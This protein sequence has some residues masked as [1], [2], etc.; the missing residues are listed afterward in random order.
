M[1]PLLAPL[2]EMGSTGALVA[3]ILT[4]FKV[5]DNKSSKRNGGSVSEKMAVMEKEVADCKET[6]ES[7]GSDIKELCDQ[8]RDF[9][10]E[11][12]LHLTRQSV[13]EEILREVKSNASGDK[14]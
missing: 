4:A 2:L 14:I 5:Y 11:V 12:R 3:V 10:E 1:D 9:R 7:M 13:R 8:F 6:L